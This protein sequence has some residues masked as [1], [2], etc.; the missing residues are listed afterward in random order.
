[1][2]CREGALQGM[3]PVALGEPFHSTDRT[4]GR[5][6]GK[7]QAGADRLAVNDDRAG[8]AHAVLA[9]DVRAGL[10]AI[11]ADGVGERAPRLDT[12]RIIASIDG[13]RNGGAGRHGGPFRAVRNAAGMRCGV[14]GSSPID[15]PNG[16]SASLMALRMA[17]GAPIVP[18]SPSPLAPVS[19]AGLR[20]SR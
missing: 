6:N 20:V 13:G 16:Q 7:H 3:E 11:L 17:A 10:T 12:D 14:A 4:S 18:P 19:V 15:P 5:L 1:M 9:A 2:V 8:A